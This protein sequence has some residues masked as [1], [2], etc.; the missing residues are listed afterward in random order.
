[1]TIV[2]SGEISLGVNATTT[3]SVA[4]EL[5]RSGTSQ[6]CMDET[7]VRTLAARTT[8]ASAICMNDFY[9]KTSIPTTLGQN[10]RGGY[11]SGT[12]TSPANYYLIVAPN[13]SG[14][15]CCQ[16]KTVST[17][18]TFGINTACNLDNGYWNTFTYLNNTTHP[19]GNY[20]A[21]RSISGFSDWYLPA[22]N[23]LNVLYQNK[24]SMPFGQGYAGDRYWTSTSCYFCSAHAKCMGGYGPGN[25]YG[26]GVLTQLSL[27]AVRRVSF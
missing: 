18:T 26:T 15:A 8:A 23:E 14:C 25:N 6:I 5:D 7:Q 24:S 11:Y 20:T 27:R 9:G 4:C 21:T 10:Y 3:R 1:M 2:A 22:R 17:Q 16:W 13:S 12:I 19:A